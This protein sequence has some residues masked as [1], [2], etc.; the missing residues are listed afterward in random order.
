MRRYTCGVAGACHGV[1]GKRLEVLGFSDE[2]LPEIKVKTQ[3]TNLESPLNFARFYLHRL[4][5][6]VPKVLYL[7]ADVIVQGDV[8]ALLDGALRRG[9]LCAATLRRTTLGAKGVQGL[10]GE[11]LQARFKKR[12]AKPLPL[13][14]PTALAQESANI[15]LAKPLT[16]Y[17]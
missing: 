4:L 9:E 12:Y 5:P 8:A 16:T 15:S 13:E 3:L 6:R 2:W 17:I 7:D 1:G 14:Q 11:K 10:R